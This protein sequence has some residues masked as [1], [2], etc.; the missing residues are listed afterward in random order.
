MRAGVFFE[1]R[2]FSVSVQGLSYMVFL[3]TLYASRRSS[4][5]GKVRFAVG[6]MG[7]GEGEESRKW[8]VREF[9]VRMKTFF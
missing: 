2:L 8:R 9:L 7:R 6:G 4:G 5:T 1:A 3:V